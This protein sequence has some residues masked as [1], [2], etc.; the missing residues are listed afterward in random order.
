MTGSTNADLLSVDSPPPGEFDFR[1]AEIQSDGRGRRGRRWLAPPGGGLCLSWSR[2]FDA[3]PPQAGALSLAVGV[4]ALRALRRFGIGGVGLKWPNDLVTPE[5]KLGGILVELRSEA[6]RALHVV[7]GIGLNLALDAAVLQD[8]EASGNRATDCAALGS[9]PDRN[10]LAAT[11]IEEGLRGLANFERHGFA[12]FQP[13]YAAAD[14]LAGLAVV[15]HGTAPRSGTALGV[16]GDGALR[17]KTGT[18][19]ERILSGDVSVRPA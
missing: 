3:L 18:G 4:T 11:L 14:S 16:D 15:V 7:V 1:A 13:E 8:V 5:G 10:A 6:G 17:L 2:S 12:P 19:I 9:V